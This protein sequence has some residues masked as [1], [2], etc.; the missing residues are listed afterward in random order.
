MDELGGGLGCDE[1]GAAA[2][3]WMAGIRL[4]VRGMGIVVRAESET[5]RCQ[6]YAIVLQSMHGVRVHE[7]GA[8]RRMGCGPGPF[9]TAVRTYCIC[10]YIYLT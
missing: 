3:A 9:R 1:A 2:G 8:G 7:A 6:C 5:C 4:F 10:A